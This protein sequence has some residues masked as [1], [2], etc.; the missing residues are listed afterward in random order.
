MYSI[1]RVLA[2]EAP[3]ILI[4]KLVAYSEDSAQCEVT[5]TQQ[6]ACYDASLNGVPAYVGIEYMAQSIAAFAGANDIDAGRQKRVGFL[7]GTRKL[8]LNTPQFTLND[9]LTITVQRIYQEDTGLGVFDCKITKNDDSL[10]EARVN[11]F[12]P[13]EQHEDTTHNE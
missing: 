8:T 7:L 10:A 12:Q 13:G 1:E 4:D 5:I 11:V 6:S 2:H 3:M 9:T